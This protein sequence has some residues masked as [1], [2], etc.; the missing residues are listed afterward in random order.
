[1]INGATEYLNLKT[2]NKTL[3]QENA[4]LRNKLK[5]A[6]YEAFVNNV[7]VYDSA[8]AQQFIYIP[9][10]VVNNSVNHQKNFMTINR[11]RRQGVEKDMAV[12]SSNGVVGIVNSVSNNFATVISILH[13]D[14]K[15]SA[16]F[17]E[18]NYF[19][20]VFW[21]G[22][23]PRKIN[24][25]DIPHHVEV[26]KGQKVITNSF[27][28]IFPSGIPLGVVDT[29]SVDKNSN[30]YDITIDLSTDIRN[31]EYVYVVKDLLK[32]ERKNLEKEIKE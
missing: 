5:T 13:R 25:S 24:F 11:G 27:S 18:N 1:M 30:F 20:T 17:S 7:E 2:V 12:I 29:F 23:D 4:T 21:D 19:G 14:F 10:K 6:K 22:K 9:A 16:K 15:V 8:Y 3:A 26:K 32:Y 28:N 31:I